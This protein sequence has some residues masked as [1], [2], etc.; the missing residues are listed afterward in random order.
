MGKK[1]VVPCSLNG[2]EFDALIEE[3]RIME[4][5][6]PQYPVEE[7]FPVSDTIINQPIKVTI[8]ALISNSPVTWRS[9]HGHSSSRTKNVA[10]ELEQ[11]WM[12]KQLCKI[13]TTGY[14]YTDM[15]IQSL[16]IKRSSEHGYDREAT[17]TAQKVIKTSQQTTSLPSI[18][19]KSGKT[20]QDAGMA[21]TSSNT[22]TSN[23]RN[24]TTG[25]G[26]STAATA[27]KIHGYDDWQ[28][29]YN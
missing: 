11:L 18:S 16:S 27:E 3:D 4:A 24:T 14:I 25:V 7:G 5:E 8:T 29:L 10:D 12:S 9:S 2:I 13:V 1:K 15:A 26:D 17:F 20:G 23:E 6:T 22:N 28:D 19:L 21:N